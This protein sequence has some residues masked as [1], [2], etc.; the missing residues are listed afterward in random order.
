MAL[1]PSKDICAFKT[2]QC[3]HCNTQNS[4]GVTPNVSA[5]ENSKSHTSE[6]FTLRYVK[7]TV[8][9]RYTVQVG[10]GWFVE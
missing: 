10:E 9:D 1:F 8:K 7:L 3:M 2:T 6:V 5:S 4:T